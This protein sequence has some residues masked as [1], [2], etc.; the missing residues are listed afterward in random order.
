LSSVYVLVS[1]R[2]SS[3]VL[4]LLLLAV[5]VLRYFFFGVRNL[6][7]TRE[8]LEVIDV[9]RGRAK[10]TRSYRRGDVGGIRFGSVSFS[11]YGPTGGLISEVAGKR[12]NTLYGLRCIEAQKVLDELQRLGFNVC[13]DP[14]MPMMIEMEESRRKSWFGRL[15]P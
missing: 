2:R 9:F 11:R 7:C 6:R 3:A 15:L 12:I 10:R 1:V 14:G 13:H 5:G 8:N 4:L